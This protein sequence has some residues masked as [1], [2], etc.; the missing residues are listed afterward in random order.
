MK[1]YNVKNQKG[2]ISVFVLMAM[3]FFLFTILGVYLISSRRAQTQTESLGIVQDKY[4]IEGEENQKYQDKI[5]A[6]TDIIPIYTKEQLWAIG[7]NKAIE[8]EGKI[9]NFSETDLTK[10]ELKNDIII[11]I[12][13]SADLKNIDTTQMIHNNYEVYY[14]YE[15]DYYV[16]SSDDSSDLIM[17]GNKFVYRNLT[18]DLGYV[19]DGLIT[20][21]DGSKNTAIGHDAKTTIW[22]DLSGNGN[23]G[24]LNG[25]VWNEDNL[26]L[27][28]KSF[29]KANTN[30][31][32]NGIGGTPDMT[33]EV[34]S[35]KNTVT[36]GNIIGFTHI[37]N[38]YSYM[39]LWTAIQNERAYQIFYYYYGEDVKD[40]KISY[41]DLPLNTK[42]S[43]SYGKNNTNYFTYLN[44][45]KKDEVTI[46]NPLGWKNNDLYI[47]KPISD[48]YYF[49]GKIYS[50]RIYNKAL[51]Q[52]EIQ[53]NY[54]I[55]KTRFNIE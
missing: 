28:G 5:A 43:I 55:D 15:D 23:D 37:V 34:I 54:E 38:S 41:D 20:H 17:N 53:Q 7:E 48:N 25:G 32:F 39:D 1:K 49:T 6:E 47:G 29:V 31:L 11:N 33:V 22:R 9:Y 27:D 3:L 13:D 24:T 46:T 42:N 19:T 50:V 45:S 14:Y 52:E 12:S 35:E 44:A 21:F 18:K 40:K 8:I 10:Y 16:L 2:A 26:E 36:Y 4:Y 51:S 30:P